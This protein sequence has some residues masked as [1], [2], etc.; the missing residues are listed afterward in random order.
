[1]KYNVFEPNDELPFVAKFRNRLL[2]YSI[3][4]DEARIA[5]DWFCTCVNN[6]PTIGDTGIM[7]SAD[8][9]IHFIEMGYRIEPENREII[10][11]YASDEI[12][13]ALVSEY[14]DQRLYFIIPDAYESIHMETKHNL[15]LNSRSSK[16]FLKLLK[17]PLT[18][19]EAY[20][21]S[22]DA[23]EALKEVSQLPTDE[24]YRVDPSMLKKEDTTHSRETISEQI[25]RMGKHKHTMVPIFTN[26]PIA[27]DKTFVSI[28]RCSECGYTEKY[29]M[30]LM[31]GN[32]TWEEIKC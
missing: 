6:C 29:T 19:T 12:S 25:A 26:L 2:K 32:F 15:L 24:R 4:D 28:C 16:D 8:K 18:P 21:I 7:N 20:P 10:Q 9:I 14:N 3:F 17:N 5:Y 1:M 31:N 30:N 22:K 11:K 13:G 23:K 27:L